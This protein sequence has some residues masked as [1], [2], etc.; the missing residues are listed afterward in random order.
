MRIEKCWFCGSPVYPGHGIAFVRNDAKVF[1]FC[2]SK[3]HKNFKMK[4][5]PRK[6]RWTKA[7]RRAHG[8]EMVVDSTLEFEK[9]RNRP[10]KYDRDLVRHTLQAMKRVDEIKGAREKSF[11]RQR[12]KEAKTQEAKA[13]LRDLQK[14]KQNVIKVPA[15]IVKTPTKVK[16]LAA[17]AKM[18]VTDN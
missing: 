7:F 6:L 15:S 12:M 1:R 14:Y 11:Y 10:V 17:P 5:N 2:R 8:K 9:R 16:V 13:N 3:C 18:E 4:R